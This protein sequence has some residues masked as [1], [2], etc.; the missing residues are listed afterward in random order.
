MESLGF[1]DAPTETTVTYVATSQVTPSVLTTRVTAPTGDMVQDLWDSTDL[2]APSMLD[3]KPTAPDRKHL[4]RRFRWSRVFLVVIIA[5]ALGAGAYWLYQRPSAV[6]EASVAAVADQAT[7]LSA[8]LDNVSVIG[9]QLSA[10]EIAINLT[11]TDLFDVDNAARGLFDASG[12]LPGSETETRSLAADAASLS[13][14]LSRQL[15]DGLAYRSALEPILLA[16]ALETDPALTDLASAALDFSEWRA[17]FESIRSALP[18]GVAGTV[19]LALDDFSSKLETR[20]SSYVDAIRTNDPQAASA[21]LMELETE[22]GSIR[23]LM[24][25]TMTGLAG[26]VD[27]GLD[28]ARDLIGRLIG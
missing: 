8:A 3:W 28:Q 4:R 21:A 9:E 16:P 6:A 22:L 18:E 25:T 26:E 23:E 17:H 13:F 14:G 20:Q 10:P 2:D 5:S 1:S 15:R 27:T 7:E 11:A 24:M 19:T 12:A